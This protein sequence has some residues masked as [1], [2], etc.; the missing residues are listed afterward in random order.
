MMT[1]EKN[2][3]AIGILHRRYI[4]DKPDRLA[5]LE[6]ERQNARVAKFLYDMRKSEGLSQSEL[7]KR[8][9]TTQS[10]ISRLEDEEY[11]GHSLS[12]LQKIAE[13]LGHTVSVNFVVKDKAKSD[14]RHAF[15]L[16]LRTMRKAKRL[17]VEQLAH[18]A[19]I[20]I[21][22]IVFLE[23]D[24]SYRPD[25]LTLHRLSKFYDVPERKLLVLAGAV[26]DVPEMVREQA[27]RFAAHSD[28]IGELSREEKE[29]LD[30]FM[31]F[32]KDSS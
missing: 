26:R 1:K 23:N 21:E 31:C 16:F 10:V 19:G 25:P 17:T 30:E 15:H 9:G 22:E 20:D 8:V 18:K 24:E 11:E 12:M 2:S 7:A 3:S 5:S 13:A 14:V 28:G 6:T 32:L 27:S 29:A 4:K